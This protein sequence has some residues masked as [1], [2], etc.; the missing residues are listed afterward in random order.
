MASGGGVSCSVGEASA[1]VGCTSGSAKVGRAVG[2]DARDAPGGGVE[3]D[4]ESPALAVEACDD[5][6]DIGWTTHA[7]C[8]GFGKGLSVARVQRVGLPLSQF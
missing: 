2:L 8:P 4:I 1:L 5:V 7:A 3:F 6:L